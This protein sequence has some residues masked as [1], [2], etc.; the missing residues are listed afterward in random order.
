MISFDHSTISLR[1]LVELL[2][3]IGY[4]PVLTL[5][6]Y[7]FKPKKKKTN[8]LIVRLAVA[9]FCFANIMLFSFPEYLATDGFIEEEFRKFFGYLN[10]LLSIP[11]L[12]MT[13]SPG[14]GK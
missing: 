2:A 9:G 1:E 5:D 3:S 14:M 13:I 7:E 10:L 6:D 4:E 12:I 11:V 8:T